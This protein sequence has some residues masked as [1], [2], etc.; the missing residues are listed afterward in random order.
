MKNSILSTSASIEVKPYVSPNGGI[1]FKCVSLGGF[2][3]IY[4]VENV[5]HPS[6]NY[7]SY[8]R[9]QEAK[10]A[11]QFLKDLTEHRQKECN[12]LSENKNLP[13]LAEYN[14]LNK[15]YWSDMGQCYVFPVSQYD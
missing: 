14:L 13:P 5:A 3:K 1:K 9:T 6:I 15:Y 4:K 8:I 12:K 11:Y 10:A 2:K 7:P